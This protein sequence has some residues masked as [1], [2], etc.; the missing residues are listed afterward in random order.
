MAWR[1]LRLDLRTGLVEAVERRHAI[2]RPGLRVEV[3]D[4]VQFAN[5][6][7]EPPTEDVIGPLCLIIFSDIGA[8]PRPEQLVPAASGADRASAEELERE[9]RY[10]RERPQPA[11]REYETAL[12]E[13]KSANEE[14][15]TPREEARHAGR[16]WVAGRTSIAATARTLVLSATRLGEWP[17]FLYAALCVLDQRSVGA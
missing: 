6:T 15:E 10:S 5:L 2:T 7:I 11:V 8:P 3:D 14:L 13:L 16:S 1:E 17:Q 12:E 9:L 4:R